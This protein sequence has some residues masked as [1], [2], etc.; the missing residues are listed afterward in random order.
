VKFWPF[1]IAVGKYEDF[2]FVV[3]P[4]AIPDR[5]RNFWRVSA[6]QANDPAEKIR[7]FEFDLDGR[8]A[9]CVYRTTLIEDESGVILDSAGRPILKSVGFLTFDALDGDESQWPSIISAIEA[10]YLE[11]IKRFVDYKS[12]PS[13]EWMSAVSTARVTTPPPPPPPPAENRFWLIC[14][15]IA[16]LLLNLVQFGYMAK[17]YLRE[18]HAAQQL[19]DLR[20]ERDEL[21]KQ[22]EDLQKAAPDAGMQR[23]PPN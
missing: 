6:F 19:R 14:L 12:P 15:L 11:A 20:H 1:V 17:I 8:S 2:D 13:L 21:F 23:R 3:L 22:F 10:E 9:Q 5:W 7:V 16:S 4:D 18:R